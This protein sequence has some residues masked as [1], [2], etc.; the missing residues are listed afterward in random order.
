MGKSHREV[1]VRKDVIAVRLILLFIAMAIAMPW[2]NRRYGQTRS[3]GFKTNKV[4]CPSCGT[5]QYIDNGSDPWVCVSC[6]KDN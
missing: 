2:T 6:S 3:S 4:R 1:R 5:E